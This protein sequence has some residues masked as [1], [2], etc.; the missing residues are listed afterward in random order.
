MFRA[1]M[2]P[3]IY[4]VKNRKGWERAGSQIEYRKNSIFIDEGRQYYTLTFSY[5]FVHHD[6]EVFFAYCYPYTYTRLQ[7]F[8][9]GIEHKHTDKMRRKTVAKTIGGT[10]SE[11]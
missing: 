8:L 2:K 10:F 3:C 11:I 7:R 9:G 5:E 6:D 1:G 4:S